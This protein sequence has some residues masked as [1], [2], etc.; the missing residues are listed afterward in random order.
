MTGQNQIDR[1]NFLTIITGIGVAGA[2]PGVLRD[3]IAPAQKP[4]ITTPNA[5]FSRAFNFAE[6]KDWITPN[7]NFFVRSHFGIPDIDISRWTLSVAYADGAP[8]S[9]SIEALMKLPSVDRVVTLECAG[10]LVGW[11]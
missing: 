3:I 8:L 11:G 5:P 1:R 10:N 7:N 6:L 4:P 2:N 9:L